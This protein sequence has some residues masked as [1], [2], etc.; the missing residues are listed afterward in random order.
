MATDNVSRLKELIERKRLDLGIEYK[1]LAGRA[2]IAPETLRALRSSGRAS[3][4]T[5]RRLE[6]VLDWEPGS[7]DAV[8]SG[9]DPTPLE[10]SGQASNSEAATLEEL[11]AENAE[12]R[13]QVEEVEELRRELQGLRDEI[14][15]LR[16]V[17]NPVAGSG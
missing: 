12:L 16:N 9:D 8:L 6:R 7:I 11:R 17:R 10:A 2:E 5:K 3:S 15:R 13:A 1:E 4:L 14:D